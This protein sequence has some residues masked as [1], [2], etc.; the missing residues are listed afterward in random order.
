MFCLFS[1]RLTIGQ[2]GAS[3]DMNGTTINYNRLYQI[4]DIRI[5]GQESSTGLTS[6]VPVDTIHKITLICYFTVI[7]MIMT[8][9][10]DSRLSICTAEHSDDVLV[11]AAIARMLD[12]K[13]AS[14]VAELF[15]ALA[16]PT[17]IRIISVLAHTEMCVG[18]LCLALEMSQPAVSYQL[19]ILRTLRIV[20]ARK[21]GKHVF[22]TL[23]DDHV[24][25]LYHQ[26]VDHIKHD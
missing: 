3:V 13:S 20:R 18:D 5:E 17:R 24:Y 1:N 8:R 22:Y 7:M 21:E 9:M 11:R 12:A 25:Q 26:G 23:E 14:E 15:K 16:D 2:T 19:R 10:N 4:S 6:K